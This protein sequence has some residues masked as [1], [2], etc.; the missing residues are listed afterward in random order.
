MVNSGPDKEALIKEYEE[1]L[2]QIPCKH[3]NFGQ[4]ACPFLNSCKYSH[5]L[6]N[7]TKYEYPWTENKIID[8]SW[9][10]DVEPTLAERLFI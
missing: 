4:G 6:K 10:D 5:L 7:G 3:F 9:Q 1:N 2:A 8:G